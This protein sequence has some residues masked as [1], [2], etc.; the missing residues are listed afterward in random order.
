MSWFMPS[1]ASM[2]VCLAVGWSAVGPGEGEEDFSAW[3]PDIARLV[4]LLEEHHPD[5]YHRNDREEWQRAARELE[6]LLASCERHEAI[7]GF[8]KLI[9]LAG[10][11]HSGIRTPPA[12]NA[13][14]KWLPIHTQAFS[15]GVFLRT[16]H[17]DY[18]ELFGQRIVEVEG[19][20]IGEVFRRLL[21]F[22]GYDNLMGAIDMFPHA[23][24]D[25]WALHASGLTDELAD[26]VEFTFEDTEGRRHVSM[27]TASSDSWIT[28]EWLDADFAQEGPKPLYRSADG[29]Y[30]LTHLEDER[31]AYVY[32]ESVRDDEGETIAEFCER[33]FAFVEAEDN[34]IQKLVLDIRENGGG[35]NYLNQPLLHGLIQCERIN[36]PGRLFVITGRDTFS[37]AMCLSVELERHTQALFVGEPTGATPN[38]YGDSVEFTLPASGLSVRCSQLFWQNSDPRDRRVWIYPDL[39]VETSFVEFEARRD[40]ALEAILAYTV[41]TSEPLPPPNTRWARE[42]QHAGFGEDPWREV[43]SLEGLMAGSR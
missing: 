39:P 23:L 12:E 27:I 2:I 4:E 41:P 18:R 35:N 16:A 34:D 24:R 20:P 10:D 3:T 25:P 5:P 15:D 30:S 21:P 43:E 37:A 11:G 6:A 32:F 19:V 38:H 26:E 1:T 28:N 22:I 17:Q 7:M 8:K 42:N 40:P 29:N 33:V 9:A 36:Q 31:L 14:R 13:G